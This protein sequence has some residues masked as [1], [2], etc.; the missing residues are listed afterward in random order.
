MKMKTLKNN[1]INNEVKDEEILK[2]EDM[3]IKK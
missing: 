3:K 2:K 1:L